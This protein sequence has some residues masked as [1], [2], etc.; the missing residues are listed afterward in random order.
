[1]EK[2]ASA[3]IQ[4]IDDT[5]KELENEKTAL[6]DM[7]KAVNKAEAAYNA[8]HSW[9]AQPWERDENGAITKFKDFEKF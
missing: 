7:R 5:I 3:K 1:M 8:H 2:A 9:M 6:Q 4:A